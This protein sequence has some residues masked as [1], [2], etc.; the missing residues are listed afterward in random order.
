[1]TCLD[2]LPIIAMLVS[3]APAER[4]FV[5]MASGDE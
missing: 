3:V 2:L 5:Y 1:V 4:D